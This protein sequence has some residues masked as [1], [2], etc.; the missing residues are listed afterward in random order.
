MKGNRRT[1]PWMMVSVCALAWSACTDHRALGTD[2]QSGSRLKA[3]SFTAE[4]GAAVLADWYD[5][6]LEVA[7]APR[8]AA[9]GRTRC[10]PTNP[11]AS[12][13]AA[14]PGG[15]VTSVGTFSDAACSQEIRAWGSPC[16]IPAY[17][18]SPQADLC[19]VVG[20]Q[21]FAVEGEATPDTIYRRSGAAGDCVPVGAPTEGLTYLAVGAEVPPSTFVELV[22]EGSAAGGGR[23]R[24]RFYRGEDGARV[25]LGLED[26][27]LGVACALASDRDGALRCLPGAADV[28]YFADGSCE[29]AAALTVQPD[30][31]CEVPAPAYG[32]RTE[33]EACR[34]RSRV[35]ALE[36]PVAGLP[37]YWNDAEGSCEPYPMPVGMAGTPY[38]LPA[39][40]EL[41]PGTFAAVSETPEPSGEDGLGRLQ[42]S[43][44]QTDDG[45]SEVG[46][47]YDRELQV[48]CRPVATADGETRCLPPIAGLAREL[49]SDPTCA[50]PRRVAWVQLES[51][52]P[53]GEVRYV[54]DW[55]DGCPSRAR[56]FELGASLEGT[57]LYQLDG[58]GGCAP[59]SVAFFYALGDEVAAASFGRLTLQ[60]A[61]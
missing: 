56:I 33:M 46:G 57:P 12:A 3:R 50:T 7:C 60:Q 18:T 14:G 2:L 53:A 39:T 9:D 41:A 10:L 15:S 51:C 16:E 38:G 35:F 21:V 25:P 8:L 34:I 36:A 43:R 45:F 58:A 31:S 26:H 1:N 55:D 42:I 19:G 20:L 49:F 29:Q 17:L 13:A 48:A 6:L 40:Q 27:Q 61:H 54:L 11:G 47:L 5:T 59:V 52:L 4:S 22:A 24:K 23:L 32:R 37:L 30:A 28:S 44:L